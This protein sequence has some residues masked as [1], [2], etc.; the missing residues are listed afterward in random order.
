MCL[1]T[2]SS[3][4]VHITP[5]NLAQHFN[6]LALLWWPW[7][8]SFLR[9]SRDFHSNLLSV[10]MKI[11]PLLYGLVLGASARIIPLTE[12]ENAAVLADSHRLI[13]KRAGAPGDGAHTNNLMEHIK[14]SGLQIGDGSNSHAQDFDEEV[15][16]GELQADGFA[17]EVQALLG[18]D[19]S[20]PESW[21]VLS[22]GHRQALSRLLTNMQNLR[23]GANP[24]GYVLGD[25]L[26]RRPNFDPSLNPEK[27]EYG[28]ECSSQ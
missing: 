24:K 21:R 5:I 3:A 16:G 13:A 27:R 1:F 25:F 14:S 9:P 12:D 20:Y 28:Q 6:A 15:P 19:A 7:A 18:G 8:C 26:P 11:L 23:F 2:P 17:P 10:F 22:E 4:A